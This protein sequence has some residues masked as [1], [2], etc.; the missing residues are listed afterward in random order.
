MRFLFLLSFFISLFMSVAHAETTA[1]PVMEYVELQTNIGTITI[2]LD[3]SKAPITANNFMA[4]VKSGFYKKTLI[5]RVIKG[6]VVQGGGMDMSSF[7]FKPTNPAIINE[8]TNGLSNLTG[9]IAMARTS[10]PN[11]A[12][13]QFYIN[14]A[15]NTN[16]DYANAS[17]PGYAVFG[18]V[19]AGMDVVK[20]I[21]NFV[22]YQQMPYNENSNLIFIDNAFATATN[23]TFNPRIR[24]VVN[25]PGKVT[26]LPV[27]I[28]CGSQCTIT[29]PVA[30]NNTIKLSAQPNLG[31]LFAG[32]RGDCQ[33]LLRTVA[34]DL[35]KGN[36]NCT[37]VFIKPSYAIQ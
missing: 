32:W 19:V 14:V 22:T 8:S 26:S 33:G 31:A 10:D 34:L 11:S 16:L 13:S 1:P 2:K 28:D 24:V 37:A 7:T 4:Y 5:H 30:V 3:Y 27:G 29:Q 23:D 35:Q 18:N 17:N 9:T 21:E 20:K 36:H 12:T 25:G 6:F 15:D